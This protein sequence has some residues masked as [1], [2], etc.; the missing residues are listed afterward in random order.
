MTWRQCSAKL[1]AVT[2]LSSSSVASATRR[3]ASSVCKHLLCKAPLASSSAPPACHGALDQE[4]RTQTAYQTRQWAAPL[5]ASV[6]S[7][8]S[9]ALHV[10][11]S[12]SSAGV[13]LGASGATLVGGLAAFAAG[14]VHGGHELQH[15]AVW[16]P[17]W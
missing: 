1:V 10:A 5:V 9:I 7:W 11:G 4:S 6:A 13:T 17:L 16:I 2:L 3:D 8:R 15:P 12:M 14:T